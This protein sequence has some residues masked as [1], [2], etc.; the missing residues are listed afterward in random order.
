VDVAD[1][2]LNGG[3]V[4]DPPAPVEKPLSLKDLAERYEAAHRNGA[5]EANNLATARMHLRHFIDA[6]GERFTV[7]DLSTQDLQG[8]LD[9]RG[10]RKGLRQRRISPTTLEKEVA[11]LRAAWNWAS[12]RARFLAGDSPT[13]RQTRSRRFRRGR[14]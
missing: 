3:K 2:L 12:S 1:Y 10:R 7:R 4:P 5:V 8:Y 9:K 13:P 6:L 11:S 14:R